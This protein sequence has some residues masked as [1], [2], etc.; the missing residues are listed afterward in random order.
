M[1]TTKVVAKLP[2]CIGRVGVLGYC[3]GG[4][5]TFPAT[6]RYGVDAAVAYRGGDTEKYPGVSAA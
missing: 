6:A 3:L 4:L 1:D 2:G 5:M